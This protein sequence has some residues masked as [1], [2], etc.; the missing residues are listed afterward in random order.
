MKTW[1]TLLLLSVTFIG[2]KSGVQSTVLEQEQR[3][4]NILSRG[5]TMDTSIN[6]NIL[7]SGQYPVDTA[8]EKE[9]LVFYSDDASS[10]EAFETAYLSL[11]NEIAPSFE[12]TMILAKMGEKNSG[13]YSIEV[14]SIKDMGR[15]VEVT[16]LSKSPDGLVTMALTNPFIMISL[17][18][19]HKEIKIIDK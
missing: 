2:C 4:Q 1:L 18:D 6:Y 5:E 7:K 8:G 11:T 16:L 12:G 3:T 17:P 13:G 15:L 10:V 14:E 9:T 19:N